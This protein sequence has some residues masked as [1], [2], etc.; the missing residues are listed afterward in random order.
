MVRGTVTFGSSG[1]IESAIESKTMNS[2][3]TNPRRKL[4]V[5]GLIVILAL[6]VVLASRRNPALHISAVA[7]TATDTA[8]RVA[9]FVLTNGSKTPYVVF[10]KGGER[11]YCEYRD[12]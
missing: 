10:G 3:A 6:L 12:T 9:A 2:S 1:K 8:N 7:P 4:A 5:A 11:L